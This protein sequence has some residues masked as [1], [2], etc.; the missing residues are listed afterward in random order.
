MGQNFDYPLYIFE[1]CKFD[2]ASVFLFL[3]VGS[4]DKNVQNLIFNN[5]LNFSGLQIFF[6]D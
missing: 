4:E 2:V 5:V 6:K 1:H 3:E